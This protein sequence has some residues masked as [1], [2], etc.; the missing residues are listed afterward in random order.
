MTFTATVAYTYIDGDRATLA[1][2]GEL[3]RQA[4]SQGDDRG[5]V[6]AGSRAA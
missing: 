2:R 3:R 6:D 1:L 4:A 5:L